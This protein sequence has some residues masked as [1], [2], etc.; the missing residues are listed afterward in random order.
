MKIS[1]ELAQ[2]LENKSFNV[3]PGW[4]ICCNCYEKAEVV[5]KHNNEEVDEINCADMQTDPTF[6]PEHESSSLKRRL[7]STL[8]VLEESPVKLHSVAPHQRVTSAK[9]KLK[10]VVGKLKEG[11]ADAYQLDVNQ[12]Q[13]VTLPSTSTDASKVADLDILTALM[14]EKIKNP[15][16][17]MKLQILTMTPESWSRK[18]AAEYFNV[19]EYLIC[20]ARKLKTQK[21]IMS[22]PTN[23]V[24][25]KLPVELINLV[26]AFYQDDEYSRLMPG[27]KDYVNVGKGNKGRVHEQKRLLLCNLHELD[28]T[29]KVIYPDAKIG[30]S[31]FCS[32]RPK[33]CVNVSSA[34]THS[35]C[36]CTHHQNAVLLLIAIKWDITYKNMMAKIVCDTSRNEYMVHRCES[37]PGIDA[38]KSFLDN[39]LE[40]MDIEEEFHFNQWRS[41]DRSQLITK[42]TTVEDYKELVTKSINNL[43][44][45]S[46][47]SKC[48]AKYLKDLKTNI[49]EY[50]CII[51]GDFAENY[52]F[53]V[54]DEIESYHWCKDSC[55]LHPIVIYYKN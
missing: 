43:T 32:S 5:C 17:N 26:E 1:I 51:L 30:F 29:F 41:T 7:D 4:K 50:E 19:S 47:I 46:Y 37:C 40:D 25:K 10:K 9:Q 49:E 3:L 35:V 14:K 33:W 18:Y 54:Q 42:T 13:D 31:K 23:K 16:F 45:H 38:L 11:V 20:K 39:E 44:A 2:L 24:G 48:Q 34:G 55:T 15:N 22:L 27:K 6:H 28:T 8:S 53:V 21:G 12:L 36:V 52:E